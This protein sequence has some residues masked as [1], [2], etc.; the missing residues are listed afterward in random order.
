MT[1][2]IRK[3]LAGALAG[4]SLLLSACADDIYAPI[5]SAPGV[6]PGPAMW[7]LSDEDTTVY[8]FGTVH[9]LTEDVTWFE[10]PIAAALESSDELVTEVDN[11]AAAQIQAQ[12]AAKATLP[13]GQ[14]L[15]DLMTEQDRH[16]YEAAMISLGL[17]VGAF[18]R[19]EPWYAALNLSLLPLM[20]AGYSPT[21]GVEIVLN[22][23]AGPDIKRDALESVEFQLDLFDGL[24]MDKQLVYLVS[25]VEA[26][27]EAV[28]SLQAMV[29]EWQAGN[30]KRLGELMNSEVADA[31]LY[32]RLLVSRN[33]N[34]AQWID[35]RMDQPGSVFIAVG[36]GHLA[37][38]GSVQEQ[39]KD[40]GFKV[41]RVH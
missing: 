7:E 27:P 12:V 19:L 22:E 2:T 9:A 6:A 41:R 26:L 39:L 14:T 37:G 33:R 8:L 15:R 36:A 31:E 23:H 10:G 30:P 1:G 24:P 3:I 25:T 29:D 5:Q 16:E 38:E 21:S 40:L 32:D 20:Q 18:D 28:A 17:P 35:Q 34:W 4:A 13:E 11:D